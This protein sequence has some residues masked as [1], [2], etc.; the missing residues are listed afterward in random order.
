MPKNVALSALTAVLVLAASAGVGAGA[1]SA[2]AYRAISGV[3]P[4]PLPNPSLA[5][6]ELEAFI[7]GVMA[8]QL[9]SQ[10][11][12]GATIAV[13]KDG[14]LF[15]AKGYGYED[16]ER[17]VPVDPGQ[18]LFRVG[19]TSKL[20]TWTA[21]MQLVEQGKLDL[22][23]DVNTYLTDFKIPDTYPE[24]VTVR[25][26]LTHTPGFEDGGLGYLMERSPDELVPLGDFLAQH[27][28]ARVRPP[29]T[30]FASSTGT[31]YSN[32]GAALAGHIVAT[33]SGMPF[34]DY[35]E[36]RILKPL[37]MS[38]STFREPLP[39]ELAARMSG[40]YT[41]QAGAFRR[42]GFE[43]IH[44]FG[45][46]GGLSTTAADMAKFMI[47][48]LQHGAV[49]EARVLRGETAR[50]M[51]ARALSP[52]P[53]VNGMCLGFHET[54][55]N[56]R[57]LI[58]HDGGTIY[59]ITDL[60]LIPEAGVG[61]FVSTNSPGGGKVINA[62]E[63]A[64]M[65]RYF[66]A[67]LPDVKIPSDFAARAARYAGTYRALRRS[68]TRLDKV[69]AAT[70]DIHVQP[71]PEGTLL[72]SSSEGPVPWVEIGEGVFIGAI[73]SAIRR[74]HADRAGPKRLR[75]ARPMLAAAALLD[76]AFVVGFAL[77]LS[78]GIDELVFDLP[79]SLYVVLALPL[80]A[81]LPTAAA[82]VFAGIVWKEHHW[83]IGGRVFYS[84]ATLFAL[85]FL[86]VINYWNLLGY[87]IG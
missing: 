58:G 40:G 46:A 10:H 59:F 19:S 77:T 66:P 69:I 74:R 53:A 26:L 65:D 2:L 87:R 84:L 54:W 16:V 79:S 51:H 29:T 23:A 75:W 56:G 64:F 81:L 62:L 13:V 80:F 35:I 42:H 27:M 28:P 60:L 5:R 72:I 67:R 15:F 14:E 20:F 49:D 18:T 24:P 50:L 7:D 48:H 73:V 11:I 17:K 33:V 55:V 68:Y 47:A 1:P 4:E 9:S 30:D 37:G 86:W 71:G 6:E 3:S 21:I 57:R 78:G 8:T 45:P 63:K 70:G 85:A 32:W 44:N 38:R 82:A 34:D 25:N 52:D 83:T 39:L 61:I 12:A 76:I 41:F 36:Q 31:A 22:D 43:Y